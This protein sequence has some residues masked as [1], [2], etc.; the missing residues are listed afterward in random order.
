MNLEKIKSVI[1]EF[2]MSHFQIF[3]KITS[4][5]WET[6]NDFLLNKEYKVVTLTLASPDYYQIEIECFDTKYLQ[7]SGHGEV[8]GFYIKNTDYQGYEIGDS[9]NHEIKLCCSDLEIKSF[10]MIH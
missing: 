5:Q 8:L 1:P 6:E 3:Q 4:L 7:F 9:V 2:E 10:E